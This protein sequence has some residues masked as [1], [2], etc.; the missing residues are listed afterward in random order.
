MFLN[1]N[2]LYFFVVWLH[3]RSLELMN[4]AF[5]SSMYGDHDNEV[6]MATMITKSVWQENSRKGLFL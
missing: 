1:F 4:P 3:I 6:C 5:H 2:E